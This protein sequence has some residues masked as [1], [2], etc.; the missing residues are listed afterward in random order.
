[1]GF[2]LSPFIYLFKFFF[3]LIVSFAK[4][5]SSVEWTSIGES[6]LVGGGLNVL[7]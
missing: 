2:F 1:M 4:R 3:A 7:E 6:K 5:K